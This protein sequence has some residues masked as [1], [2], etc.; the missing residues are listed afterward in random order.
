MKFSTLST[1]LLTLIATLSFNTH[2]Q[3]V[4]VTDTTDIDVTETV[5]V[6]DTTDIEEITMD[7]VDDARS[8]RHQNNRGEIRSTILDY[9][10]ENGDITQEEIDALAAERAAVKVELAALREAGDEDAL[11]ARIA[12]LREERKAAKEELRAYVD[13]NE[14]LTAAIAEQREQIK[15][16]RH[17][18]N[19]NHKGR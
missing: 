17:E 10:L 9:M 13:S 2:A 19:Q 14:E 18:R 4:D 6:T 5:D 1:L 15:E 12:E 16:Q 8:R 3:E 7:V 11:A